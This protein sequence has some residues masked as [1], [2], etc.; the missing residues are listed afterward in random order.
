[1][2]LVVDIGNTSVKIGVFLEEVL[3]HHKS[4][5]IK[6][7]QEVIAFVFSEFDGI[8][9]AIICSVGSLP[10]KDLFFLKKKTKTLVLN[11]DT[12]IPFKNLYSTPHTLGVD[13]IALIAAAVYHNRGQNVLIID[14]GTCITYDFKNK[15]EEFLG[16]AISPGIYLR[17]RS[18]HQHTAK[19]PKLSLTTP[20]QLTGDSTIS[21]IHSGVVNGV[22]YEINGVIEEY[23][24]IYGD[25][26]VILTGGDAHFLSKRLKNSIFATSNFLLEGLNYI[27]AFNYTQ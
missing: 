22:V 3:I 27:L 5:Q 16:G 25:L 13:R 23:C 20:N 8:E 9:A 1:M 2:N 15:N 12:A 4:F 11:E 26:T 14:A 10:K 21:A 7:F 6:D 24:N 17:Y 18:L 19:L